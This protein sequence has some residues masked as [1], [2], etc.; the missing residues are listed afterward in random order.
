MMFQPWWG[1]PRLYER[2]DLSGQSSTKET[3]C[4][5]WRYDHG[6]NQGGP[7]TYVEMTVSAEGIVQLSSGDRSYFLATAEGFSALL[8][9][10][11]KR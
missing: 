5:H 2:K 4:Y 6:E 9:E 1:A 11:D 10:W 7:S 8:E 3:P